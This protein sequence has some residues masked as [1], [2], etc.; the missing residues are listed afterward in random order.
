MNLR[1]LMKQSLTHE[2]TLTRSVI[3]EIPDAQLDHVAS[4]GMRSLKW[5]ISHL[6]DIPSWVNMILNESSFDVAPV[7]GPPHSTHEVASVAEA[8][9]ILD[10][11]L[12]SA[13][14]AIDQ[15]DPETYEADWSLK[16]G[17]QILL[18]H[19]RFM[20]YQMYV[21]NHIAHHR[22]HVLVY[23][24]LLGITMPSIYG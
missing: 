13:L 7:D 23:A 4:E 3:Q 9:K 21:A 1:S 6:A 24:R 15:S 11:N 5:N 8:L 20:I 12:A 19:P 14:E 17:G 18:T 2:I 22:A 16:A 10:D